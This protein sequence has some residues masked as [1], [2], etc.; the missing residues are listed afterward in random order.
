M[1]ITWHRFSSAFFFLLALSTPAGALAEESL[2]AKLREGGYV[3]YM[4]H[5]ATDFGQNDA[6]MT[7]YEDCTRQRNL[8]DQGR[9][10]ARAVGE[11]MRRLRIPIGGVLAS[12]FCRT[13]ETAR[14]AFGPAQPMHEVRGGPSRTDDPVR[15]ASLKKLLSTNVAKGEN[16][17]IAS[18]G[19]P[20]YALAGPPYLAEGEIAVLEPKDSGFAVI[21]R[22]RLE[23]WQAFE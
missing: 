11:Q 16:L 8:T 6:R 7:S 23:D 10:E 12:P 17:V 5:A 18:H 14:L 13:M 9:A 22:I 3:L 19:N 20:F 21:G 1:A 4:R 15:Y 2:V